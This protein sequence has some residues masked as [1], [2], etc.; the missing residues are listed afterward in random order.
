MATYAIGDLQGCFDELRTLLD[1]IKFDPRTDRLWLVGDLVNRGPQ[2]LAVLRFIKGLGKGAVAV[3][4]NH[5][6]HLLAVA[7]GN[8]KRYRDGSLDDVLWAADRDELLEWLRHRPL[9]YHDRHKGFTLLHAG[10]PPQWDLV[11][12]Q[13]C[14]REVE[15][16]LQGDG[17]PELMRELYGNQPKH[18]SEELNGIDRLRFIINCLTRL[19]YCTPDGT[20]ALKDKG[21]PGSQ[22]PGLSPWFDVPGR[23]SAKERIICGHWS[24]LGFACHN[25]VWSLDT[26]C[27]WG[28][29]LTALRVRKH[30]PLIPV[31][32]SCP[33]S[34]SPWIDD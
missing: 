27:L 28:G 9:L 8:R 7:Q 31:Q 24:T 33:G 6:L 21:P 11:T 4:G 5:D 25:N 29:Q 2:S 18:W 23:A 22:S 1:R 16:V 19:R 10:L 34:L 15:A 30:K 3:L 17:F 32:V 20:L 13:A 26:G 12:A 14:A